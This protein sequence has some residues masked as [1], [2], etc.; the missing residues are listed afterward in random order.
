MSEYHSIPENKA[1][2]NAANI[3][4]YANKINAVPLWF[5]EKKVE[6]IYLQRVLKQIETGVK[7]DVDHVVPLQSKLVCG[8]HTHQNLQILTQSE[9]RHKSNDF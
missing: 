7:H 2:E 3:F 8:L 6:A 5:N 4:N 1:K 9:N